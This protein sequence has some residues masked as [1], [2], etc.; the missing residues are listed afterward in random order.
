[1]S[2]IFAPNR[3]AIIF[4][5]ASGIGLAAARHCAAAH[6]RVVA[7]DRHIDAVEEA[8]QRL[9][10]ADEVIPHGLDVADL[11]AMRALHD[12]LVA[13][14][15]D[16]A[17][18]MNNAGIS[19]RPG[20][21]D[22][23]DDW[24]AVFEVNFWGVMNGVHVFAP[25]LI[26][27]A[28]PAAIVNT[29]SK[30]GLTNPPVNFAYNSTKAALRFATEGLAHQLRNIEGCEVS[31]HLLIPGFTYTGITARRM[32]EKPPAAWT[33]D[34]VVDRMTQ[35]VDRG[36]F[37]ILCPD[38]ETTPDMDARR[39]AWGAADIYENRPALSRWDPAF[40]DAFAAHMK[41]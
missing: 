18:V 1:M 16:I 15:R 26:A 11:A 31:A 33:P 8:A 40:K 28:R 17:L 2:R 29:G 34:Q 38:N 12:M 27:Q 13:Q 35:G 21:F 5:A 4:G 3:T 39:I 32:P 19:S 41:S 10:G 23:I 37:Y 22:D 7:I 6:M 24:R 20:A 9:T 30:Q 14:H 36:D 25:T